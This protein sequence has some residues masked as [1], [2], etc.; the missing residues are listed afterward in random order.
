MGADA[1]LV[2]WDP[3]YYNMMFRKLGFKPFKDIDD[4]YSFIKTIGQNLFDN[5]KSGAKLAFIIMDYLGEGEYFPMIFDCQ[6]I[7]TDIGFKIKMC[8]DSPLP[9]QHSPYMKY[10]ISS[11]KKK[12][13]G[14]YCRRRD[15]T[16][17]ER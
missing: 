6:K 11:I 1:V 14:L 15:L 4:F 7:L 8:I 16:I 9:P 12:R 3:P 13:R 17:F 10:Q 2:Y 5:M